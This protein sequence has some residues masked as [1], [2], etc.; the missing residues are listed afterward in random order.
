MAKNEVKILFISKSTILPVV[1]E[2]RP[3]LFNAFVQQIHLEQ[4]HPETEEVLFNFPM[5]L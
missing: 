1:I 4:E 3:G 2:I 5:I